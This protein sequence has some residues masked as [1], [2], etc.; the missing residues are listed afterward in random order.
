M[1]VSISLMQEL[2]FAVNSEHVNSHRH[3]ETNRRS[4]VTAESDNDGYS[5][6]ML[7]ID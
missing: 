1:T 6:S 5:A 3:V 7:T 2:Y 4:A